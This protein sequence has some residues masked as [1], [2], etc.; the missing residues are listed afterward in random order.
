MEWKPTWESPLS[1]YVGA[2]AL[3]RVYLEIEELAR[4]LAKLSE[5]FIGAGS[6]IC[7]RIAG[8]PPVESK[9]QRLTTG[10]VLDKRRKYAPFSDGC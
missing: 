3:L 1:A 10:V 8:N 5:A 4:P 9:Q 6:L 7:Q 2:F